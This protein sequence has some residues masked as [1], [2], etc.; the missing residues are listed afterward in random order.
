M[1]KKL[2]IIIPAVVIV[3]AVVVAACVHFNSANNIQV[4]ISAPENK[5]STSYIYRIMF[6]GFSERLQASKKEQ[7]DK[8]NNEL[9]D[10]YE[11]FSTEQEK[12]YYVEAKYENIDDK[13][14]ITFKGEVTDKETG[15]LVEFNKVFSY[16]FIITDKINY[17]GHDN[18]KYFS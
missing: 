15:E 10:F 16:D 2:A 1:K 8:V 11:A 7:V 14:V 6:G 3:L 4:G 9:N 18:F 13:T 5:E 17:N 12:P